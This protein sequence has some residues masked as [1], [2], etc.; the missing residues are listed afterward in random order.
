[1]A[2]GGAVLRLHSP[3]LYLTSYTSYSW[4]LF[5]SRGGVVDRGSL[6]ECGFVWAAAAGLWEMKTLIFEFKSW[7]ALAVTSLFDWTRFIQTQI[8][9]LLR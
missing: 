9:H 1:M 5:I 8:S 3:V 6:R 7:A 2:A 4:I